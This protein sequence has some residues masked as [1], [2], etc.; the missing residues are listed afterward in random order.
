M[1]KHDITGT[2]TPKDPIYIDG[3]QT[4]ADWI[5]R[6]RLPRHPSLP[7]VAEMIDLFNKV[8]ADCEETGESVVALTDVEFYSEQ[9]ENIY[10]V[11]S[12]TARALAEQLAAAV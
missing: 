11:N 8:N 6:V 12:K 1:S 9:I 7:T 10:E 3:D 2:G 4:N 5:K